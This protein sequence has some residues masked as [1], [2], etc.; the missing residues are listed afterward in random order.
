MWLAAEGLI[1]TYMYF[2][3]KLKFQFMKDKKTQF[4]MPVAVATVSLLQ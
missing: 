2:T 3:Q 4:L 1:E